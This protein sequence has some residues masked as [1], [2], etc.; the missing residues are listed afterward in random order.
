MLAIIVVVE[1]ELVLASF[2]VERLLIVDI[3]RINQDVRVGVQALASKGRLLLCLLDF[4]EN[5]V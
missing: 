2:G 5:V 4:I 3:E 1:G